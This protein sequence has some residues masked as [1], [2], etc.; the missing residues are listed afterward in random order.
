MIW[1]IGYFHRTHS[2]PDDEEYRQ[3]GYTVDEK[4]AG[5]YKQKGYIVQEVKKE[6]KGK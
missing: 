2:W 4:V 3:L 5:N 6:L 1:V